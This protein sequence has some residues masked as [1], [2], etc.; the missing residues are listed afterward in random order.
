VLLARRVAKSPFALGTAES[1]AAVQEQE[2]DILEYPAESRYGHVGEPCHTNRW[3][4]GGF[5]L[6]FLCGSMLRR[7]LTCLSCPGG[8]LPSYNPAFVSR[9]MPV[10]TY[11]ADT[12]SGYLRYG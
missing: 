1:A 6:R 11:V 2:L 7:D 12:T 4:G 5:R 9:G 8:L 3:V 10:G